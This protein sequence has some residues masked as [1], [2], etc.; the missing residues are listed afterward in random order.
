M[1]RALAGVVQ[2]PRRR[3]SDVAIQ[4]YVLLSCIY[5]FSCVYAT[6]FVRAQE[7]QQSGGTSP[8]ETYVVRT[9]AGGAAASKS[10]AGQANRPSKEQLGKPPSS[11]A[12]SE[13]RKSQTG[14]IRKG[15]G[16]ESPVLAAEGSEEQDAGDRENAERAKHERESAKQSVK[17]THTSVSTQGDKT[18]FS[19]SLSK[20]VRAEIFT[21]AGPYRIIIDLPDVAFNL[22][23]GT[24]QSGKGLIS[25][26]RYGLFAEHKGRVVL[27]ASAPVKI[28]GAKM[29]SDGRG[30][31]VKLELD[32]VAI[33][34]AEFG[35]GTGGGT[36]AGAPPIARPS[37]FDDQQVSKKNGDKPLILV[38][39]GHGGI[40]P[41]AVGVGNILEKNIVFAVAKS[42]ARKL[43]A[44]GRY[45]VALT[46]KR[47][48]FVTLDQRVTLSQETDADLF[49]SLHADSIA[50]K[51][52]APVVRGATVYTLSE[53][54][55]DEQARLM[56]EKENSSD[57]VAGIDSS[58]LNQE[59][60]AVRSILIDLM[61]RETSNFSTRFSNL[62][63]SRLKSSVSLSR[64]PQ[65]S[66]AFR[67]LK[68]AHAPSVLVELGYLS[69]ASDA[70]LMSK[71]QWQ[72]NVA[73]SIVSALDAFFDK[74]TARTAP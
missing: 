31:A 20:G 9:P 51:T 49:I 18:R 19:M 24:G 32:L 44:T 72:S 3:L 52:Y 56:A 35:K 70:K 61:K 74:R 12:G 47:D 55:S 17:V 23:D 2:Q 45:R 54:A 26:F 28:D 13:K 42:L 62:L 29:V 7:S 37:V 1:D 50:S 36:A 16:T 63:V 43:E 10:R 53:R 33:S 11:R 68:Q 60:E 25:A 4:R 57:L 15:V 6:T 73:K 41:G 22:P 71:S 48:V 39:P 30:R 8:F 59:T 66:A 38:D 21:L 34:E 5:I 64:D 46:R 40:D 65:R 14:A 27:D 69:N 58:I 67:V